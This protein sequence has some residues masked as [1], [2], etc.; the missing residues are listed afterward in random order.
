MNTINE[1]DLLSVK[2][3]KKIYILLTDTKTHMSKISK[4]IT[5]QPY[6]HVSVAFDDTLDTLY[7]YAIKTTTNGLRGGLMIEDR[8]NLR[9]SEFSLYSVGVTEEAFSK[10]KSKVFTLLED[11]QSTAYNHLG[12]INAIFRKDIFLMEDSKKMICSQFVV[13][14]LR[15]AGVGVFMDKH[16]SSIRPYD[17]V[18]SKLLKFER[19]GKIK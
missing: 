4:V 16:A 11:N 12:L 5:K 18:R 2:G 19:R 14:L 9:G 15:T 10:V 7:T 17:L 3:E 13:E 1:L 6:N 8:P